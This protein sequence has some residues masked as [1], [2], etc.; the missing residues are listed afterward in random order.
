[1]SIS[2]QVYRS[3]QSLSR[4]QSV[5]QSVHEPACMS[6]SQSTSQSTN[7]PVCQSVNDWPQHALLTFIARSPNLHKLPDVHFGSLRGRLG[8]CLLG[9]FGSSSRSVDKTLHSHHLVLNTTV[10]HGL[11]WPLSALCRQ[12]ST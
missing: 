9:L 6:I 10:I 4:C 7:Q 2:L 5:C 3:V 12:N 11:P 1:M 8:R